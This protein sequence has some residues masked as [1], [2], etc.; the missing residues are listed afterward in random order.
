MA[1]SGDEQA[2]GVGLASAALTPKDQHMARCGR[3]PRN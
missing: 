3:D 2:G 1:K